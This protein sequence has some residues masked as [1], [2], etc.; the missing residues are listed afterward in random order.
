MAKHCGMI[1]RR[2]SDCALPWIQPHWKAKERRWCA[3]RVAHSHICEHVCTLYKKKYY[4]TILLPARWNIY[5]LIERKPILTKKH[6]ID[7]MSIC[8][9]AHLSMM[10]EYACLLE[11]SRCGGSR[12]HSQACRQITS[13]QTICLPGGG[14]KKVGINIGCEFPSPHRWHLSHGQVRPKV[15]GLCRESICHNG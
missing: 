11:T 3:W 12:R 2:Q 9:S 10:K 14:G 6:S 5:L 15:H 4:A 13:V 1:T 7:W 8:L